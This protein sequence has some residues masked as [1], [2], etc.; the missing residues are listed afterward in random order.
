MKQVVYATDY[1]N[2]PNKYS[3]IEAIT[4]EDCEMVDL[5][6][7]SVVLKEGNGDTPNDSA[8]NSQLYDVQTNIRDRFALNNQNDSED[9]YE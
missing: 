3:R 8:D 1:L 7:A 2:Q 4:G 9:G 5:N 6:A